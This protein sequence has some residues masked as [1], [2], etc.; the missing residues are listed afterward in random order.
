[1]I[2]LSGNINF[3]VKKTLFKLPEVLQLIQKH[4]KSTLKNI[5][6]HFFRT[7]LHYIT[8]TPES[9]ENYPRRRETI[10]TVN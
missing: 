8:H 3:D 7:N 4:T 9:E 5:F 6:T 10:N 2:F 1:M